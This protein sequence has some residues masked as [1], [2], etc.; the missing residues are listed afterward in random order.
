M[1]HY[2]NPYRTFG[3]VLLLYQDPGPNNFSVP[4]LSSQR[5][6]TH[7]LAATEHNFLNKIRSPER[8]STFRSSTNLL[9]RNDGTHKED[10]EDGGQH[11]LSFG[12]CHEVRKG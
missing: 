12:S 4:R 8:S 3:T 10:Q 6:L 2:P 1:R 5:S 9:Q 11:Q 7:K